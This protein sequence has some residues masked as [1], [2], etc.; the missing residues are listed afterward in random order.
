MYPPGQIMT[1]AGSRHTGGVN[2]MLC[3]GSARFVSNEVNRPTWQ[4]LG[5]RNGEEIVQDSF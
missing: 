1:T 4:A 3:D 5:S 2:L